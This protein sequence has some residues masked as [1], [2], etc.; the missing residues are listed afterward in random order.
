[1]NA[2][3]IRR[4][5]A[6]GV[7]LVAGLI[8]TSCISSTGPPD[9]VAPQAV[10]ATGVEPVDLLAGDRDGDIQS[11]MPTTPVTTAPPGAVRASVL[12]RQE[13][14]LAC[15]SELGFEGEI[16]DDLG[17]LTN[18]A[19]EQQDEFMEASAACREVAGVEF[20][21]S[22]GLSTP[23]ELRQHY[24]AFLYVRECMIQAGY[25]TDDPPSLEVYI[26]SGG[27]GWHPYD[28]FMSSGGGPSGFSVLEA[29]CPQDLLYLESVL[30]LDD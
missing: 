2:L 6:M 29:T 14:K 17:I 15:L 30:D 16:E 22:F 24:R 11:L 27:E 25:S 3:S 7:V 21:I 23:E 10:T 28:A 5:L 20:G 1:M 9:D 4:A 13:F 18:V 8:W 19:P 26:E 12:E